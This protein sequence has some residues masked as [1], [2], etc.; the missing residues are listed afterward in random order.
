MNYYTVLFGV[1]RAFGV[2]AQLIWDRA[3]GAREFSNPAPAPPTNAHNNSTRTS[4]VLLY[5]T[6]REDVQG[7]ELKLPLI[8]RSCAQTSYIIMLRYSIVICAPGTHVTL[9]V[10]ALDGINFIHEYL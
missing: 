9:L 7:Q 8:R 6:H 10:V 1:S 3:L 4:E 2:A 5:C